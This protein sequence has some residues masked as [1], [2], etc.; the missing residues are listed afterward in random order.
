MNRAIKS[1]TEKNNPTNPH[2]KLFS[3]IIDG[4]DQNHSEIPY[5]GT[6]KDLTNP[7]KQHIVAVKEHGFG[8]TIYRSVDT[9]SKGANFTMYCFLRQLEEFKIRH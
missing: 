1:L 6:Q 8:V 7:L 9:I 5:L 3:I 2:P 4:M